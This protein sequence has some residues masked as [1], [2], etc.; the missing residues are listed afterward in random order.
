MLPQV[1]PLA[2]NPARHGGVRRFGSGSGTGAAD[3][4]GRGGGAGRSAN[5]HPV[6][7]SH[8]TVGPDERRADEVAVQIEPALPCHWR[9]LN[10]SALACQLDADQALLPAT[11]YRVTVAAG[12]AAADG[13]RLARQV[14]HEFVTERP[15]LE[16]AYVSAWR[17]PGSPVL[18]LQFNLPVTRQSVEQ[19]LRFQPAGGEPVGPV[20]GEISSGR[21]PGRRGA[22]AA[23]GR[24]A[25][26]PGD[27]PGG[28]AG[29]RPGPAL[30]GRHARQAPGRRRGGRFAAAGRPD[31]AA[32]PAA[33]PRTAPGAAASHL[34]R[35]PLSRRSLP[36][37]GRQ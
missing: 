32:R 15:R 34:P 28:G 36:R 1:V 5:R 13:A 4:T 33:R 20:L 23:A 14:V 16:Q 3:H 22:V 26:H 19:A 24:A 18:R 27:A 25:F 12:F 7:P 10:V 9:W 29:S 31:H 2:R 37:R 6:Q 17:G 8:G 30:L 21:P 11:R 35:L